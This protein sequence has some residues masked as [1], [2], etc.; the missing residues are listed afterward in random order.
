MSAINQQ[1][2]NLLL[3]TAKMAPM[4][5]VELETRMVS[6]PSKVSLASPTGIIQSI[7]HDANARMKSAFR[8]EHQ[9][10]H[11]VWICNA[12]YVYL[13]RGERTVDLFVLRDG[14]RVLRQMVPNTRSAAQCPRLPPRLVVFRKDLQNK[15]FTSNQIWGQDQRRH[16]ATV[17]SDGGS[18]G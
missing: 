12:T 11:V 17:S 3:A 13:A 2:T 14:Q 9:S 4:F 16:P 8:M 1:Q 7:L 5:T 6:R 18:V 10:L 15:R